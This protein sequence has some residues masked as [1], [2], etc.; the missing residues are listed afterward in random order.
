LIPL[1]LGSV[2][3][4]YMGGLVVAL[5]LVWLTGNLLRFFIRRRRSRHCVQCMFCG[6]TYEDST[7]ETLPPCPQCTKANERIPPPLI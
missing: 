6:T 7:P 5:L 2:L 1:G 3:L 4:A